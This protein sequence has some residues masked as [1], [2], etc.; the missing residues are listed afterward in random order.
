MSLEKYD[1]RYSSDYT[2]FEFVSIG[3]KGTIIKV[4]EYV[5][6]SEN[7]FIYNLGFGDKNPITGEVSDLVVSDNGDSEKVLATVAETIYL[8][9]EQN[10]KAG[11]FLTGSTQ[12]R[13]RLYQIGIRRFFSIIEADFAVYG[14]NS[15]TEWEPFQ[16]ESRYD[17]FLV[18]RK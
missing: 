2:H 15:A 10:R 17:A 11:V 4:I 12:S 8:F 1:F 14:L 6:I 9:T 7:P 13:T 3:R 5:Q 18:I 16:K